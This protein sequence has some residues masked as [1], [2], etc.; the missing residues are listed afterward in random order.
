MFGKFLFVLPH[1]SIVPQ[2][3]V[4]VTSSLFSHLRHFDSFK[5]QFHKHLIPQ[6]P[7]NR[8]AES[9]KKTLSLC[10]CRP[11]FL[12]VGMTGSEDRG[13]TKIWGISPGWYSGYPDQRGKVLPEPA[14]ALRRIDHE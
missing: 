4:C 10:P 14:Q 11:R 9:L 13:L 5:I 12:A 3:T 8:S 2:T 6:N 1:S 7:W